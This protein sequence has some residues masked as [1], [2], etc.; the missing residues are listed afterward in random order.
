MIVLKLDRLTRSVRDLADLLELFQRRKVALMSVSESL[1]TATA[2]GRM[3]V[4]MLGTVAQW[5]REA[6]GERTSAALSAKRLRGERAGAVPYG[7]A[8]AADGQQLKAHEK[9]RQTLRLVDAAWTYRFSSA[10][11]AM[12]A[13]ATAATPA[14]AAIV[15]ETGSGPGRTTLPSP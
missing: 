5:E 12:T 14:P 10:L 11:P 15:A 6:I 8:L 9:E 1:N 13:P 2:A 7:F 3:V 4:N